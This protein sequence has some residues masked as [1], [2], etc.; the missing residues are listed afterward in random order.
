[1]AVVSLAEIDAD[2]TAR[3]R[4]RRVPPAPMS[5]DITRWLDRWCESS[6]LV[7]AAPGARHDGVLRR[8][9]CAARGWLGGGPP[10]HV[11]G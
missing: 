8:W 9:V 11:V 1:M 6:G 4:M 10:R 2:A 5:S 3:P 7:A